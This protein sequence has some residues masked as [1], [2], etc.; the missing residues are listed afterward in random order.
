[1]VSN[2]TVL[3]FVGVRVVAAHDKI[4]PPPLSLLGCHLDVRPASKTINQLNGALRYVYI[5]FSRVPHPPILFLL[6]TTG[7]MTVAHSW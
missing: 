3:L 1:M 5:N 2:S 7:Q 6:H 4:H